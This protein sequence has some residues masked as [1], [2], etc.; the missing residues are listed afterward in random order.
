MSYRLGLNGGASGAGTSSVPL[1]G[2]GPA[3]D[4]ILATP[5]VE[6]SREE[7]EAT[8]PLVIREDVAKTLTGYR[9]GMEE[10]KRLISVTVTEKMTNEGM[11]RFKAIVISLYDVNIPLPLVRNVFGEL[12]KTMMAIKQDID[13]MFLSTTL[14][15]IHHQMSSNQH[16]NNSRSY[17]LEFN[18]IEIRQRMSYIYQL[19]TSSSQFV[20][21][22]S[23]QNNRFF[24]AATVLSRIPIETLS[25]LS[26]NGF[27]IN[28]R[29]SYLFIQAGSV[30][31]ADNF[32]GRATS[33]LNNEFITPT[34][35]LQHRVCL[36]HILDLKR[37]FED[38]AHRYYILAIDSS[39]FNQKQQPKEED[40]QF[41][42]SSHLIHAI[43][44]AILA[45]A[46]PRRSRLLAMLYNDDRSKELD[47]YPLL[48]SIHMGRLLQKHHVDRLRPT[49][50]PHQ[51]KTHP[52]G[53]TV[54]DHAI[55]EHN[56]LAISRM[57]SNIGLG[58]LADLLNV[59]P[60]K[61]EKTA[62]V[63]INE[64]RMIASIDQVEHMLQFSSQSATA[65]IQH[66]DNLIASLCAQVDDC[67]DSIVQKHSLFATNSFLST[68]P[69]LP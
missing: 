63:M 39:S 48:Q 59:S 15:A 42:S 38:A 32:L 53:D 12:C 5:P 8:I 16:N 26:D 44:C 57:Y 4:P 18:L 41:S 29:I 47:I 50:Q 43:T 62:R 19:S 14:M 66:W 37:R 35:R 21:N 11:H 54:L 40:S 25:E 33:H 30:E 7:I 55:I 6:M 27:S 56:M 9:N 23:G 13:F 65:N 51:L 58:Q 3:T 64:K 45:P 1:T 20:G 17:A 24:E 60:E 28:V 31:L 2:A 36:A 52:D 22:P 49:L 61:A 68:T 34:D 10:I 67:V 46:G 69:T